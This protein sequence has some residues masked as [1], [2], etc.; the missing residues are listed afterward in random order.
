MAHSDAIIVAGP[1]SFCS[2]DEVHIE[3]SLVVDPRNDDVTCAKL[4]IRR[5]ENEPDGRKY[6]RLGDLTMDEMDEIGEI[7]FGLMQEVD[8]A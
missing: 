4:R 1:V 8:L 7:Y 5:Y 3:V 2:F 6:I